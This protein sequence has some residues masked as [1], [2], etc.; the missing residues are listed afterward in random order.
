M[1]ETKEKTYIKNDLEDYALWS[2]WFS[3]KSKYNYLNRKRA[4]EL[5][6]PEEAEIFIE[7]NG[8][9]QGEIVIVVKLDEYIWLHNDYYGSCSLCDN[10][11]QREKEWTEK[12]LTKLYCF[13]NV[14]N[15]IKYVENSDDYSWTNS[16]NNIKEKAISL[17]EELKE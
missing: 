3:D 12:T 10:F 16:W 4:L 1:S 2:K 13:E 7:R 11:I 5:V 8:G 14:E 15:A 9:Y 17:L 6:L